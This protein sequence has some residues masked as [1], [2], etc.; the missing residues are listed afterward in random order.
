[1]RAT[2]R[3]ESIE[4]G[5]R[6]GVLTDPS[7]SGQLVDSEEDCGRLNVIL[8]EAAVRAQLVALLDAPLTLPLDFALTVDVSAGYGR[9][10]AGGLHLAIEDFEQGGAMLSSPIILRQFEQFLLTTLLVS[11]PHNYS[12]ALRRLAKPIASR[13]V[14][15]AVAFM[16][17]HLA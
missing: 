16:E 15:R 11:H 12:A 8:T 3:G 5:P 2:V 9:S 14:R 17:A 7:R 1:L 6:R 10:L 13:D 4:C